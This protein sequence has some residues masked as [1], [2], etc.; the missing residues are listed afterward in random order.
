MAEHP[1]ARLVREVYDDFSR[2][3]LDG[4]LGLM[5]ADVT[6]HV[7]GG[8][9]LAGDFKGRDAVLG[10]Y[11]RLIQDSGGSLRARLRNVFVDGRGHAVALHHITAERGSRHY[12]ED[13][14]LVFRIVGD[15]ITDID[16][17]VPDIDRD[18]DF[19]S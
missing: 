4:L 6:H 16:E 13:G 2:A 5:T 3:D 11:R 7:P 8:H 10:M 18:D 12:A 9:P 1:H 15:K 19:W 17:C 14:C